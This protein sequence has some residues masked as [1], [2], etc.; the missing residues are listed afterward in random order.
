MMPLPHLVEHARRQYF[1]D[2]RSSLS[3][4]RIESHADA[5]CVQGFV[6]DPQDARGFMHT[7]RVQAPSVNW[8]D[9]LTP[10]LSGPDYSWALNSRV[11]ADVRREPLDTAERVTQAIFG[12]MLEVLR[13]Q[14]RWAFVRLSDGYLGWMHVEPLHICSGEEAQRYRH[15]AT[16]IIKRPLVPCYAH[17]SGAAHEQCALL[18]LGARVVLDGHA[19][20]LQRIRWPDGTLRWV[21]ATDLLAQHELPSGSAAGLQTLLPWLQQLI[22]VPYLWGGRTAFGL[23]CSG[24]MQL[25]FD[26][27]GVALRRDA[28]QQAESGVPIALNDLRSGDLLFFDTRTPNDA[29]LHQPPAPLITHVGLAHSRTEFL[30]SSWR[31]G[32]VVWSSLDPHSPIYAPT[33]ERRILGARRF[34][35]QDT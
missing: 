4:I 21:P 10:L 24:L 5:V 29:I 34:L 22:G 27:L 11:V 17:G 16:A 31:A 1:T 8:R 14:D 18:P 2:G 26:M 25:I 6:L 13:Y 20:S 23:D 19:S 3:E 7:L 30:H 35:K 12:E 28:D 15:H 32:G 9:E 33:F